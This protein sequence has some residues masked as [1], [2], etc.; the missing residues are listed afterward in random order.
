MNL[1]EIVKKV[2]QLKADRAKAE[3]ALEVQM[4]KLKELGCK[5]LSGARRKLKTMEAQVND[6]Q[7]AFDEQLQ[8]F[9]EK[10]KEVL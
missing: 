9:E 8:A 10:W 3:G 5:S 1:S 2:E 7:L 6:Q 4:A